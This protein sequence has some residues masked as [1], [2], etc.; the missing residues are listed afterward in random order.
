M[1]QITR[2]RMTQIVTRVKA[3]DD[4]EE[5]AAK[6]GIPVE[7]VCGLAGIEVEVAKP[8][9]EKPK[10]VKP[11]AVKPKAEPTDGGGSSAADDFK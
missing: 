3:G 5:I 8:K 6:Y 11:K 7:R 1:K 4:L 2:T 10:A 9:A